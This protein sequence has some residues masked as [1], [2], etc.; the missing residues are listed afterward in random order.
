MYIDGKIY[1]ISNQTKSMQEDYTTNIAIAVV[2]KGDDID[3]DIR[4]N[5]ELYDIEDLQKDGWKIIG[6]AFI[7]LADIENQFF[8]DSFEYLFNNFHEDIVYNYTLELFMA[9]FDHIYDRMAQVQGSMALKGQYQVDIQEH[10]FAGYMLW[11]TQRYH[12]VAAYHDIPSGNDSTWHRS[13]C[14]YGWRPILSELT[15][16]ATDFYPPFFLFCIFLATYK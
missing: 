13:R 1:I 3:Y 4:V 10:S 2:K 9:G 16:R 6:Y 5:F 14:P 15:H 8:I 7:D 12:S 11:C